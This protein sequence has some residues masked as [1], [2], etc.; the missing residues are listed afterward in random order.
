MAFDFTPVAEILIVPPS[1]VKSPLTLM[2]RHL[3][4][5][6]ASPGIYVVPVTAMSMRV[7]VVVG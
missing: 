7:A 4:S 5:S 6:K 2:P 1:K 3:D